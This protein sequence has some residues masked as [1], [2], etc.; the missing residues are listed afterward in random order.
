MVKGIIGFILVMMIGVTIFAAEDRVNMAS[1]DKNTG[2]EI[3]KT[4]LPEV[5]EKIEYYEINGQSERELRRQM[6]ENG[7]KWDDGKTYD[8]VTSWHIRWDYDYNCTTEG[9]TPD[10]FK[11]SVYVTFR[12][13]KW[14]NTDGAPQPLV[15]KWDGYIKNLITHENGHRDMAVEATA[16]LQRSVAELRPAPS[17]YALDREIEALARQRTAK[18]NADSRH[19]DAVTVH[20][21][22]Q[23]AVFP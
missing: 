4:V 2:L 9:C 22:T 19:Y 8:S 12:Y 15:A 5:I 21:T 16:D 18:L 14:V 1:I 10:S 17:R 7:T 23:G 6:R 3:M 11:A 13:P 20:G